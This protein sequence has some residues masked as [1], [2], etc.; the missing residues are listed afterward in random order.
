[1]QATTRPDR[2]SVPDDL[3]LL[4]PVASGK[5]ALGGQATAYVCENRTCRLPVTDPDAFERQIAAPPGDPAGRS[6]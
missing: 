1:V 5:E 3:A 6:S 4:V 2:G